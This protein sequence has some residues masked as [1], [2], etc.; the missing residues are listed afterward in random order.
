MISRK[1]RIGSRDR[2]KYILEKGRR[3][4][5]RFFQLRFLPN[6]MQFPRFAV[7]VA[8]KSCR[9]AVERNRVRRR[10][11]EAIRLALPGLPR[12]CYDIA[13]LT[14]SKIHRAGFADL[15][16]DIPFLLKKISI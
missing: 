5:G 3:I 16:Q 7:T 12:T 14:S 6:Q 1:Y 4:Q 9:T 13:V 11:F 2:I 8:R 10:L 15:K